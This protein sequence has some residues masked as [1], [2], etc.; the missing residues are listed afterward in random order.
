MFKYEKT[1]AMFLLV[2]RVLTTSK[3]TSGYKSKLSSYC[4]ENE[5][6]KGIFQL[7]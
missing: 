2:S 6:T 7:V 3:Q 4:Q 5:F 1:A